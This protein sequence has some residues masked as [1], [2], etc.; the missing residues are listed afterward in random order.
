M[1]MGDVVTLEHVKSAQIVKRA[2]S[3][4]S[5]SPICE[6][7]WHVPVIGWDCAQGNDHAKALQFANVRITVFCPR[8][9]N[10][11]EVFLNESGNA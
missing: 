8:C 1:T 3:L 7:G 11:F 9:S 6:C 5:R 2:E 10:R 4:S